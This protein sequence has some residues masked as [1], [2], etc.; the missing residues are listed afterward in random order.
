MLVLIMGFWVGV[1]PLREVLHN[2][3]LGMDGL[4]AVW[5]WLVISRV[6]IPLFSESLLNVLTL[7]KKCRTLLGPALAVHLRWSNLRQ[8]IYQWYWYNS[9]MYLAQIL[10]CRMKFFILVLSRLSIL[11]A[12]SNILISWMRIPH[13]TMVK[14]ST[15]WF[16][17]FT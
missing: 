16:W 13:L 7:H 11:S 3:K 15:F 12:R 2:P 14:S 5:L 6:L 1:L 4:E 8:F 9:K 10:G 17:I